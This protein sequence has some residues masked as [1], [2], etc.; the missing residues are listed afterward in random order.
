MQTSKYGTKLTDS[1]IEYR[2]Q[3]IKDFIVCPIA[4]EI[5]SINEG[6][7]LYCNGDDYFVSYNGLEKLKNVFGIEYI[8]ERIITYD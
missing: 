4:H 6:E 7:I 1:E 5:L 8:N 3:L 2:K